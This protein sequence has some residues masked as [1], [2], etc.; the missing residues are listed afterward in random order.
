[1]QQEVGAL[2]VRHAAVRVVRVLALLEVDD[3]PLVPRPAL[4]QLERV[5]ERLGADEVREAALAGPVELLQQET[6][7]VRRPALVEPEV[8]GV[9]VAGWR[10]IE[11]LGCE[12]GKGRQRKRT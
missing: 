3:E 11:R 4:V 2:V 5:V 6:L 10:E 1:M 8:G 7:D 12:E 9:G